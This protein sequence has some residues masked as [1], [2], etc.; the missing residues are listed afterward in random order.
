MSRF[1]YVNW[2]IVLRRALRLARRVDVPD[3]ENLAGDMVEECL[4]SMLAG[5]IDAPTGKAL[6]VAM[7]HCLSYYAYC[8]RRE[9]MAWH[10][11]RHDQPSDL[12]LE[13]LTEGRLTLARL[14][15]MW[16]GLTEKAQDAMT[17]YLRGDGYASH[18]RKRGKNADNYRRAV[19]REL[20]A[21]VA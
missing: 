12:D 13:R 2:R 7:R 15:A 6:R 3:P 19:V 20:A 8:G 4:R 5:R 9:V 1:G 11:E 17:R 18:E 14:Q 10:A 21:G 16:P